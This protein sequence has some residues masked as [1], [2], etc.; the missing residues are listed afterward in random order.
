MLH[1]FR[2]AMVRPGRDRLAGTVEV[3]ETLVGGVRPGKRGRGAEGKTLVAVAVELLSPMGFGRCRLRVIPNAQAP[4][5]RLF[6]LDYVM[7][8]SVV[9]TDGLSPYPAAIGDG[10]PARATYRRQIQRSGPRSLARCSSHRKSSQTMAPR[11]PSRRRRS[12]PSPSVSQRVCLSLQPPPLGVPRASISSTSRTSG[13][14]RAGV[15]SVPCCQP[16]VQAHRY[17]AAEEASPTPAFNWR[18]VPWTSVA[19]PQPVVVTALRWIP[20]FCYA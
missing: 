8:G 5:L 2:T 20:P 18:H 14:S 15:V 4:T 19:R 9:V 3:D 7:P 11:D 17:S 16:L 1:R 6:L 10:L 12:G 13:P